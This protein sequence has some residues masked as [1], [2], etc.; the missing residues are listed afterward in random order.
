MNQTKMHL[1]KNQFSRFFLCITA[2]AII[3]CSTKQESQRLQIVKGIESYDSYLEPQELVLFPIDER[4]SL[5][6][7]TIQ[8]FETNGKKILAI[9]DRI[10]NRI[11][12]FDFETKTFAFEVKFS[13]E[14]IHGI[15]EFN[16]GT[17]L[18]LDSIIVLGTANDRFY[19]A[20]SSGSIR[21]EFVLYPHNAYERVQWLQYSITSCFKPG[22]NDI[23]AF[24]LPFGL[25]QNRESEAFKESCITHYSFKTGDWEYLDIKFPSQYSDIKGHYTFTHFLGDLEVVDGKLIVNFP[26]SNY[27]YVYDDNGTYLQKYLAKSD[28][29]SVIK[30]PSRKLP[31]TSE[32]LDRH[33]LESPAYLF[34]IYD[35][36]RKIYYRFLLNKQEDTSSIGDILKMYDEKPCSIIILDS[37]FNKIGETYLP[38]K[39]Y[40][41]PDHFVT[42]KG[43]Y[44]STNHPDNKSVN[45]DKLSYRLFTLEK[46]N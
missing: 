23:Y 3:S 17:I 7:P 44:I 18:S 19:L 30:P 42:P 37:A 6:N 36:Y 9:S 38:E 28:R 41:I 4:T 22:F 27:L 29:I 39:T 14:G 45:E 13:K 20:D 34:L 31:T 43:L 26:A 46:I 32:E 33:I 21:K 16:G 40:H 11:L 1:F 25:G 35:S 15:G 10:N 24:T 8:Y 12:A 5:H 2:Y